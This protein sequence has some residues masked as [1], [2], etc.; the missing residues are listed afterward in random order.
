[1]PHIAPSLLSANFSN[2]ERELEKVKE[3]KYLHLDVMDGQFVP[4]ITFGAVVIK[5]LRSLTKMKF[6]THLMITDPERYLDDF[7]DAGSDIVTV[8]VEAA[9]DLHGTIEY[10]KKQKVMAG[11]SLNPA[12]PLS[13]V[14]DILP[15]LDLL[16]V[17]SVNPGFGGQKLIPFTLDKVRRLRDLASENGYGYAIEV[18]GG[19]NAAT[20]DA[21]VGAGADVL[22]MGAAIFAAEDGVGVSVTRYRE[23]VE[24][25]RS[26]AGTTGT[27]G[28]Q[29]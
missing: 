19:V 22:V 27:T 3:A 24:R 4:N 18:D 12:T 23:L 8:H 5:Q 11:V 21:V 1:M 26:V 29:D 17:M 2:L 9:K 7:I 16:L 13:S 20:L 15:E 10:I 25:A 28:T 6:D 14:E